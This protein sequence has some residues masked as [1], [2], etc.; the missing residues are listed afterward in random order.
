M[1]AYAKRPHGES[2]TSI[3]STALL[4]LPNKEPKPKVLGR[5]SNLRPLGEIKHIS[6]GRV[7]LLARLVRDVKAPVDN[8]LHLMVGVLVDKRRA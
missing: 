6:L 3:S 1:E 4:P 5:K 8:N 7:H 2:I